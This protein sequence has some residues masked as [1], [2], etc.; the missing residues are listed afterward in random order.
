MVA[1]MSCSTLP[2]LAV[3]VVGRLVGPADLLSLSSR[4]GRVPEAV[5]DDAP[6]PGA[7]SMT[8]TANGEERSDM[9]RLHEPHQAANYAV[10]ASS[11][12]TGNDCGVPAVLQRHH[13]RTTGAHVLEERTSRG[14]RCLINHP[15]V[16]PGCWIPRVA[17]VEPQRKG[18]VTVVTHHTPYKPRACTPVLCLNDGAG[19]NAGI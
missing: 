16:Q 1:P 4:P 10:Y 5:L 7:V 9:G 12:A 6:E 13:T 14:A 15:N 18:T 3:G 2:L 11:Q 17:V 19:R 8:Q